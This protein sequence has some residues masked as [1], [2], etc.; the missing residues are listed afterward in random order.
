MF[1]SYICKNVSWILNMGWS[2]SRHKYKL[3]EQGSP[4]GRDLW[5]LVGIRL[6]VSQQCVPWQPRGQNPAIYRWKRYYRYLYEFRRR[7][8][9]LPGSLV[10]LL[11][12]QQLVDWQNRTFTCSLHQNMNTPGIN[13]TKSTILPWDFR[14]LYLFFSCF[15]LLP[16]F[17]PHMY[18]QLWCKI[19]NCDNSAS[20]CGHN[21]HI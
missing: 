20:L 16:S 12:W 6:N 14:N 17:K 1:R 10:S 11:L 3:V 4:A 21:P 2:G 15:T 8:L 13:N 9:S 5:V 7:S 18:V 19:L